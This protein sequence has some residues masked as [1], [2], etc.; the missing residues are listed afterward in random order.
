[1]VLGKISNFTEGFQS[2]TADDE[3]MIANLKQA[4]E[5]SKESLSIPDP[6]SKLNLLNNKNEMNIDNRMI[7]F[8]INII[9]DR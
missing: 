8:I 4:L 2:F 3:L 1:M 7:E 5:Y 9:I 6:S